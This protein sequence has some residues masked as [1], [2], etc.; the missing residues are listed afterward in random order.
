MT[1]TQQAN[2]FEKFKEEMKVNYEQ[3]SDREKATYWV[4]SVYGLYKEK[5]LPTS[6]SDKLLFEKLQE[7]MEITAT[8]EISK[9]VLT[10]LAST[11]KSRQNAVFDIYRKEARQEAEQANKARENKSDARIS[12]A[13]KKSSVS[14]EQ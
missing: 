11:L 12:A 10:R 5:R 1:D 3:M 14:K 2:D 8:D 7:I 9:Q 4:N 6:V 13:I